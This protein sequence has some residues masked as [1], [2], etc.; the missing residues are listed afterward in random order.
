MTSY[1]AVLLTPLVISIHTSRQSVPYFR[2]PSFGFVSRTHQFF[3]SNPFTKNM[4][5]T[6][7]LSAIGAANGTTIHLF[8]GSDSRQHVVSAYAGTMSCTYSIRSYGW[9]LNILL[10]LEREKKKEKKTVASICGR[11]FRV[12]FTFAIGDCVDV[13]LNI[14]AAIL[15]RC[16]FLLRLHKLRSCLTSMTIVHS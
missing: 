12:C 2:F 13:K 5:E 16:F 11:I 6:L 3:D 15:R 4:F 14:C 7:I 1:V 10:K 8:H 9:L